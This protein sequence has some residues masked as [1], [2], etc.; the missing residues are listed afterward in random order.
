M[1]GGQ[2]DFKKLIRKACQYPDLETW[3][4][5]DPKTYYFAAENNVIERPEISRHMNLELRARVTFEDVLND[6]RFYNTQGKW[7]DKSPVNYWAAWANGWLDHP[8]VHARVPGKLSRDRLWTFEK[9]CEEAQKYKDMDSWRAGHKVSYDAAR[10]NLW[11]G[12]PELMQLMGV[13]NAKEFTPAEVLIENP[14]LLICQADIDRSPDPEQTSQE[15]QTAA[16]AGRIHAISEGLYAKGYLSQRH[17]NVVPDFLA[18]ALK[19]EL[20]WRLKVS[21]EQQAYTFGMPHVAGRRDIYE[22][23]QHSMQLNL[24]HITGKARSVLIIRK[25]PKYRME[26]GDG[27]EDRILRALH[28][29]P[30][31]YLKAETAK[32]IGKLTPRQLLTMRLSMTRV[33][34]PVRRALNSA[35][36]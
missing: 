12:Q 9:V 22:S 27:Y 17:A 7:R 4:Q 6:V 24:R 11:M 25:V 19:R 1:S 30:A 28:A 34:D 35:L 16:E 10:R 32:A 31:K 5:E 21:C 13:S 15:L 18:S 14:R 20:G 36:M 26:L 23:D 2:I 8:D 29:V 33:S 3:R